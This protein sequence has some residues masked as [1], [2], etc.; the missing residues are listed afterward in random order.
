MLEFNP[1]DIYTAPKVVRM[2]CISSESGP[3]GA[4]VREANATHYT[5]FSESSTISQWSYA[6][7]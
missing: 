3:H 5:P 1:I 7:I 6:T 2:K 4:I